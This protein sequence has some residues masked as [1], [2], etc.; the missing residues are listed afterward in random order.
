MRNRLIR[1]MTMKYL[2]LVALFI[3]IGCAPKKPEQKIF[4]RAMDEKNIALL[5]FD[6]VGKDYFIGSYEVRFLKGG[7][8]E[9]G[10]VRGTITGDTL[11]DGRLD[12][13]SYGGSRNI[14]PF[15]LLRKDDTLKMGS[16]LIYRYLGIPYFSPESIEFKDD[17][18]QFLPIDATVAKE[19][20]E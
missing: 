10:T 18:F 20:T 1:L 19:I 13:I 12:Y 11:F 8:K 4:Y 5:T 15:V 9:R 16:G 17:D 6:E 3:T 7:I 2:I 14:K